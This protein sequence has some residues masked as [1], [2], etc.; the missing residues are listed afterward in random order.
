M[1]EEDLQQHHQLGSS[2]TIGL[3]CSFKTNKL[4]LPPQADLFKSRQPNSGHIW[5]I[6]SFEAGLVPVRAHSSPT[7]P[8]RGIK[9]KY[10]EKGW[11][12]IKLPAC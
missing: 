1:S 6:K 11:L 4:W 12:E 2:S 8:H 3:G 5:S 10:V 7:G 9:Q